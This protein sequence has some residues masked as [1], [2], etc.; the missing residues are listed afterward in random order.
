[1]NLDPRNRLKPGQPGDYYVGVDLGQKRDYTVAA[2]VEKKEGHVTLRH[3]KRFPLNTEYTTILGYLKRAQDEFQAVRGFFI[4]QTGV[5]E[6][7]VENA[8]KH[9]LHNVQGIVLTLPKKME[10]M[11]CVKQT[12]QEQRLHFPRDRPLEIE[13]NGEI[14]ELTPNGRTKFYHR[15]GTHDDRLWA[16]ALAVYGARYDI[17]PYHSVVVLGSRKDH[18]GRVKGPDW[19]DWLRRIRG[20]T[21]D[22]IRNQLSMTGINIRDWS[23]GKLRNSVIHEAPPPIRSLDSDNGPADLPRRR[24]P[25]CW[26][27]Y[28]FQEGMGSPCRHVKA[29][30]TI[31]P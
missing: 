10:V 25:V 26:T 13:M 22:G 24:C 8:R 2:V 11:T 1:V 31:I 17:E 16:V 27:A 21:L 6:V 15:T 5:G 29:D 12:M 19:T 20:D 28:M 14:A 9:G 30:G 3:V 7:F 4:D 23:P 18:L